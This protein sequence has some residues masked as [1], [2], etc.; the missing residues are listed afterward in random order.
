[1]IK[2]VDSAPFMAEEKEKGGGQEELPPLD[3]ATFILSLA[4]SAQVHL[5]LVPNPTNN[6]V[7]K[8]LSLAKQTIDILGVLQDKTKGNLSGEEEKLFQY[9]LTDLRLRY[10]EAKK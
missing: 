8:N 2:E 5:G 4:S 9:V 7:E 1:M 10:L 3:F 6:Q